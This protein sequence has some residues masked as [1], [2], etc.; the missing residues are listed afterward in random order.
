[1]LIGSM[2][3][4][5]APC[6][7]DECAQRLNHD[8]SAGSYTGHVDS[9][10]FRLALYGRSAVRIRGTFTGSGTGSEVGYRV[11]FIPMM[12]WTLLLA[13]A[14]GIP[15]II[16]AIWLGYVPAITLVWL[17][18]ITAVMLPLNFWFSDRHAVRLKD[19]VAS[20]LADPTESA[21]SGPDQEVS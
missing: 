8:R 15:V 18:A 10:G 6:P 5:A 21:R 16:A 3:R 2:G 9:S 17:A 7:P 1:M 13:Y 19:H 20:V 14:V 4:F 11:E 12:L